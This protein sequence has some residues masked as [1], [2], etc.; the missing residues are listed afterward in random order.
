MKNLSILTLF[1]VL[2][3]FT[4]I[5]GQWEILNEDM[6]WMRGIDF[7]NDKIGWL[8]G[9]PSL[10]N[11]DD[12]GE[13]WNLISFNKEWNIRT[14]DFINDSIGW[15]FVEYEPNGEIQVIV[16]TEDGGQ[17]WIIQKQITERMRTFELHVVNENVVYAIGSDKSFG[18]WGTIYKTE[19]GGSTWVT[20][21]VYENIGLYS[22]SF[23]NSEIGVVGGYA[24]HSGVIFLKTFNGGDTWEEK[25][26]DGGDINSIQ[27]INDTSGYFSTYTQLFL[28]KDIMNSWTKIYESDLPI[29]SFYALNNNT[30]FAV[31]EDSTFTNIMKSTDRGQSWESNKLD[32]LW[33]GEVYFNS[34]RNGFLMGGT[35]GGPIIYRSIDEGESWNIQKFSYPLLDVYF[36]DKNMGFACGGGTGGGFGAHIE[37]Q[38]GTQFI[39]KDGGKIWS[40]HYTE[41]LMIKEYTYVNDDIGYLLE[42]T[43]FTANEIRI[44]KTYNQGQIWTMVYENNPDITG[45]SFLGNDLCFKNE[46][47]GWA[48]GRWENLSDGAGIISTKDGGESW[49]FV[50]KYPDIEDYEYT[51]NSIHFAD[52]TG[53]SVGEYGLIVKYTEQDQ[54]QLIPSVTDLPLKKV[55]FSDDQHGWIAGGYYDEDNV[56][57]RLFKTNDGGENWQE[58]ELEIQINDMFFEDS[59]HGWAVGNDTS[60][61]GLIL[62]SWDGG[63]NWTTQVEGL[64]APLNAL[65]F[66]DGYGWAVGDNGLVLRTESGT[67]WIDINDDKS[68]PK[69]FSLRQYPNPFNF[70]TTIEFTLPK[71]TNVELEI[72]SITGQKIETL[73]N[74]KMPAGKHQVQFN[75][76]DLSSGVYLYRLSAGSYVEIKK[77][78]LLK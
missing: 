67:S 71:G 65:H 54:W 12:G 76:Q 69:K 45:Y 35:D 70:S 13:T 40:L 43:G 32:Y 56:F 17:T 6:D 36:I 15:A 58:K 9:G 64:S 51:L 20:N 29:N 75:G 23:L 3:L 53:W 50:W 46:D 41:N 1:I 14:F 77:M 7:V 31:T 18:R 16:K 55:F 74:R 19:N 68:Y 33:G 44:S 30:I 72:F 63:D 49:D 8:G 22:L 39:T 25:M 57:L 78:I 60:S 59:L 11:T 62:E 24:A 47:I 66:K 26:T 2:I 4:S 28:S 52:A 37:P 73:L 61:C 48:V 42:N 34:A 10:W 5:R 38:F 21:R 27:F